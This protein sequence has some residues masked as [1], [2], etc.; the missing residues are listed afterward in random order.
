MDIKSFEIDG[1]TA[2]EAAAAAVSAERIKVGS[3]DAIVIRSQS[4]TRGFDAGLRAVLC[5][6]RDEWVCWLVG[7]EGEIRSSGG[8]GPDA[9]TDWTERTSDRV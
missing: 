4:I 3:T 8:Y 6:W 1:Q 5:S 7:S 2:N 9:L